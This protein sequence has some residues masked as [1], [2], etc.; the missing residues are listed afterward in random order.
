MAAILE[1]EDNLLWIT[2]SGSNFMEQVDSCKYLR[3]NYSAAKKKWS[4]SPGRL[5][6]VLDEFSEYGIQIS[7]YDKMEINK[8]IDSLS[9]FHKIIKRSER[10]HFNK[11]LMKL[12]PFQPKKSVL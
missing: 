10:R 8:Y 6:E 11:D 7:E 2:C 4:I 9:T 5:N 3:M 1:F 12:P